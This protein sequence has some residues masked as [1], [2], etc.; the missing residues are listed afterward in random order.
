[1]VKKNLFK[2]FGVG[3]VQSGLFREG[4]V[5]GLEVAESF[6]E[7]DQ[8]IFVSGEDAIKKANEIIYG[9]Q[10]EKNRVEKELIESNK[11]IKDMEENAEEFAKDCEERIKKKY[12]IKSK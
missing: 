5:Q 9:L 8:R 3:E 7:K 12:G 1:M 4:F 10:K 6:Y 2:K 11:I